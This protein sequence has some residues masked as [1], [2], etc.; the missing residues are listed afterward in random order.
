MK[1]RMQFLRRRREFISLLGGAGSASRRFPRS[2]FQPG[3][4]AMYSRTGPPPSAFA[5]C[6]L[7][8]ERRTTATFSPFRTLIGLA[9][10]A[11]GLAFAPAF[12]GD[13]AFVPAFAVFLVLAAGLRAPL[14]RDAR[15]AFGFALASSH[16]RTST[17][18]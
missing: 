18:F 12:G 2:R 15:L 13:S 3:I 11:P 9:S 17:V 4:A 5:I 7:P 8:P 1:P 6:G 10:L 14:A 16:G